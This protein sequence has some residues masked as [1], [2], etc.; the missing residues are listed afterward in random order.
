MRMDHNQIYIYIFTSTCSLA[1]IIIPSTLVYP[2]L[3]V[4][5]YTRRMQ[6]KCDIKSI[7]QMPLYFGVICSPSKRVRWGSDGGVSSLRFP[8]TQMVLTPTCMGVGFNR[9]T[10]KHRLWIH[11]TY[12]YT[13]TQRHTYGRKRRQGFGLINECTVDTWGTQ[14]HV[15]RKD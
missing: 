1:V 4:P 6:S 15:W 7:T 14:R 11:R 10:Y 3:T 2:T 13:H 5:H 8:K 9:S 12:T